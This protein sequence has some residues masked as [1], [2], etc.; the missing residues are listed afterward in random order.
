[1]R[2]REKENETLGDRIRALFRDQHNRFVELFFS[3]PMQFGDKDGDYDGRN[4]ALQPADE[5]VRPMVCFGWKV[6][7]KRVI[8]NGKHQKK[9]VCT[10]V[11][12]RKFW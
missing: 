5:Y 11:C 6:E 9:F 12:N 2:T 8:R 10:Y 4:G 1:M 3:L 7:K